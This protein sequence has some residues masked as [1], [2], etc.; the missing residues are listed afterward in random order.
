VLHTET[1][2]IHLRSRSFVGAANELKPARTAI[3]SMLLWAGCPNKTVARHRGR[4]VLESRG[5]DCR[6]TGT[7]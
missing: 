6:N 2:R 1:E 5:A 7:K 3:Y 4:N